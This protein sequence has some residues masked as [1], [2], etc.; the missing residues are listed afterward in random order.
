MV[1]VYG[2]SDQLLSASDATEILSAAFRQ[3]D[4]TNKRLLFIIPDS[5]RS[6]PIGQVFRILHEIL[7][8]TVSGMDFL[9]AL[10]T[11]HQMSWKAILSH[12]NISE[13]EW[14]TTY[15]NVRVFNHRWDEQETFTTIGTIPSCE[16]E[17]L[18]NGLLSIDVP[19]RLNKMIY[20]Y[21]QVCICGPVFPHEVVGISGGNKY[22]FPGISGQEVI[23]FTHWLGALITSRKVIGRKSTPV[24]AV[25]DRAAS[26]IDVPK[27]AICYV[28]EEE[29]LA[30]LYVGTPEEAWSS[31]ADLSTDVHIHYVENPFRKVLSVIPEMYD[32][33]WTGAKGMYKLEPVIEDGGEVII[34]APHITE[35]SYT[36]GGNIEEVGYHVRD[37]FV[38]QWDKFQH[39]PWGVLAH[40]THFRGAGEYDPDQQKESPRIDVTLATGI[41]Q[42]KCEQVNLGYRDPDSIDPGEWKGLE[43]EGILLVEKAGELLYRLQSEKNEH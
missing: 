4:L 23:D 15:E 24:R 12:L 39:Y 30:G 5:T 19:V 21:D 10:G 27:M 17:E 22:F 11:H 43:D 13:G 9:I 1:S 18:S 40:S 41:S 28:V 25:I 3:Y 31:A 33:M 14:N 7:S 2:Y 36:H 26:Y 38:E 29:G 20:D 42:D 8:D 35:F 34:Y 37:Y 16:I 32:D 6:G